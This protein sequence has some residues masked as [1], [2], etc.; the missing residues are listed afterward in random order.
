MSQFNQSRN[1]QN[2]VANIVGEKIYLKN[3]S[4]QMIETVKGMGAFQMAFGAE[5]VWM[6]ECADEDA[7]IKTLQ[8]LNRLGFLFVG[9]PSGW[10]AA[11]VFGDLL[12]KKKLDDKFKEV[13][14]RGPGDWLIIERSN[15]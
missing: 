1:P 10:P 12:E 14:W 5:L 4:S 11:D 7:L 15:Q 13:Q 9:S 8:E 2:L 6:I 3:M